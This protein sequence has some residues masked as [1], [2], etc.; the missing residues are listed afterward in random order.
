MEIN[1]Y[2]REML[3]LAADKFVGPGS[4][5]E[6]LLL[7]ARTLSAISADDFPPDLRPRFKEIHSALIRRRRKIEK[8]VD[9]MTEEEA[10]AVAK[11]IVMLQRLATSECGSHWAHH[12][13][14]PR[15]STVRE[16]WESNWRRMSMSTGFSR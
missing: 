5:K 4:I 3:G 6:R 10:S 2:A 13:G 14:S 1:S 16:I 11:R 9:A 7:A 15:P 8:T 12:A